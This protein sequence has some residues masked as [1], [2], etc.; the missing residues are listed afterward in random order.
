[1]GLDVR[2]IQRRKILCPNCGEVVSHVDI[3][4]LDSGGRAW[5]DPLESIGYYVPYEQRTEG[6]E[7]YGKD[8]VLDEKQA[9]HIR[10]F[11][12]HSNVYNCIDI[13]NLIAAASVDGDD[14][15]INADW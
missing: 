2:V 12:K 14:V 7:W 6:N 4:C 13:S 3:E 5:Y 9:K 8:M 11:V 10:D 1:M 15:V